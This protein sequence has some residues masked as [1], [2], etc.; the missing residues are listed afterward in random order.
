MVNIWPVKI[1]WECREP[2]SSQPITND[3]VYFYQ[4]CF[5][6]T[7]LTRHLEDTQGIGGCGIPQQKI[8]CFMLAYTGF[9]GTRNSSEK[10]QD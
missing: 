5:R 8:P 10:V 9:E 7:E 3:S 1:L 6:L 4:I 2:L